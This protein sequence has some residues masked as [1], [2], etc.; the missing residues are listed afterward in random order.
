MKKLLS[1]VLVLTLLCTFVLSGC[2]SDK[3]VVI[4]ENSVIIVVS[5]DICDITSETTLLSYMEVLAEKGQFEFE[6]ANGMVSSFN[7]LEASFAKNEFWALYTDDAEMANSA[8]G[9][10]EYDGVNYGSA[11]LGASELIVKDGA[12]YIWTISSF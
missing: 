9:E 8:W 6:Y 12:T 4:D 3:A 5:S 11:T 1:I 7:E 10:F 2:G